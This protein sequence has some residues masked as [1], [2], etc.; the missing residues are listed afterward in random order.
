VSDARFS[1]VDPRAGWIHGKRLA[2]CRECAGPIKPP[3]RSFCSNE[4]VLAWK[5]RS[6]PAVA[7][8]LV[9]ERDAGVCA[10]CGIDC[11]ALRRELEAL[12]WAMRKASR[13]DYGQYAPLDFELKGEHAFGAR[14]RELG[15]TGERAR[16]R[17]RLWEMDHV[18]PVVEGGG[19]CGLDN[20]R[21]L[22]WRCHARVTAE[23][24]KRMAERRKAAV[25]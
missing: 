19:S 18:V 1:R 24:R 7:A 17:R 12:L 10:E 4:C 9:L 25:T 16:L 20:L 3:A 23:L 11:V 2:A 21:T 14:I 13:A 8:R 22:C 15:L 6:Q 5:I